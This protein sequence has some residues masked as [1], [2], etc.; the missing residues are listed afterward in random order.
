MDEIIT[1][2]NEEMDREGHKKA[3]AT[4]DGVIQ[5]VTWDVNLNPVRLPALPPL[6]RLQ[7]EGEPENEDRPKLIQIAGVDNYIVGLTQH[8][9]VVKLFAD[10]EVTVTRSTWQYV[11]SPR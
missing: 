3:C 10:D 11:R 2:K 8:G 9:H 6:P 1:A 5:C 7:H 4:E